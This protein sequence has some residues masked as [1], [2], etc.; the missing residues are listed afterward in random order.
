MK[1]QIAVNVLRNFLVSDDGIHSRECVKGTSDK[2]PVDTF[3]GLAAEGYVVRIDGADSGPAKTAAAP[4][5][6]DQAPAGGA[7][8]TDPA[9]VVPPAADPAPVAPVAAPAATSEPVP[10]TEPA[11]PADQTAPP[12]YSAMSRAELLLA[13]ETAGVTVPNGAS[14]AQIIEAITTAKKA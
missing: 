12:N 6:G 1:D 7:A 5:A 3:E 10:P 9:A 8:A 2:V 4:V 14:R 13:A 11:T